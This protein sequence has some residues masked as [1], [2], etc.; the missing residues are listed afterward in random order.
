MATIGITANGINGLIIT[1]ILLPGDFYQQLFKRCAGAV[2]ECAAGLVV[3]RYLAGTEFNSG[4]GVCHAE[5][6]TTYQ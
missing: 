3:Y 2:A 6:G 5:P 4:T 1:D